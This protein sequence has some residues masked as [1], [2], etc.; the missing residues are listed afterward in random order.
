MSAATYSPVLNHRKPFFS[1]GDSPSIE[2]IQSQPSLRDPR[3]LGIYLK[4]V[5]DLV[6]FLYHRQWITAGEVVGAFLGE[7]C[8]AIKS[9]IVYPFGLCQNFQ[10]YRLNPDKITLEQSKLRPKL[11]IHGDHDNQSCWLSLAK[12]IYMLGAASLL[13]PVFTVNLPSGAVTRQDYDKI[14][15]KLDSIK[16]LYNE[17]GVKNIEFDVVGHSRGSEIISKL[18][19]K[20]GL[21]NMKICK[22]ILTGA[23]VTPDDYRL[24]QNNMPDFQ[25]R[26]FE[27]NGRYDVIEEFLASSLPPEQRLEINTGH[28]G[29]LFSEQAHER[30]IQF[31]SV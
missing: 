25:N 2:N 31:L 5:Q 14:N 19:A 28:L 18:L 17:H 15:A 29:L 21:I 26:V 16:A 7:P 3:T 12:K 20:P 30:I 23:V 4:T 8:E 11:L 1:T 24:V 9:G 22:A 6:N 13:G 10:Y 27:I